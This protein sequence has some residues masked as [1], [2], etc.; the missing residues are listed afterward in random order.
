MAQEVENGATTAVK[1]SALKPQLFVTAQKASDAVQFYK[2]AFGAEEVGR[3]MHP[4][5]KAEQDQPLVLSADLKL[6]SSIFAVSDLS[7]DIASPVKL[8]A[9]SCVFCLE[10]ENVEAAIAKAVEAGAVAEGDVT[11]EG[12]CCGGRVGKVKDPYGFIWMICSPSKKSC[13][14]EA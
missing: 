13:D 2:T 4:K 12:A 11:E 3:T 6:G 1:F 8:D 14:A 10:T 7:D 9:G 5:R